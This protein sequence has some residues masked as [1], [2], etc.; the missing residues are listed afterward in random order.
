MKVWPSRCCSLSA[1]S[2]ATTSGVEPG[3]N[4]TM[5]FT[6]LVGQSCA[7][8]GAV[9][10]SVATSAESTNFTTATALLHVTAEIGAAFLQQVLQGVNLDVRKRAVGGERKMRGRARGFTHDEAGAAY[11]RGRLG[12]VRH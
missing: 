4:G 12:V 6:V 8:A 11:A 5:I 1:T 2:R 9:V 10:S 7:P 3:P